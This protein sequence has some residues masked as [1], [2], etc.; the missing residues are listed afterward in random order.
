MVKKSRKKHSAIFKVQVAIEA[1][2]EVE[3][4]SDLAKR[5]EVISLPTL[6]NFRNDLLFHP[7]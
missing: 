2:K 7:V 3:T 5:V 1:I 6:R 4:L